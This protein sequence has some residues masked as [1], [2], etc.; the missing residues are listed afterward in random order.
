[1][2]DNIQ[3]YYYIGYWIKERLYVYENEDYETQKFDDRYTALTKAVELR[4][5]GEL[6][7]NFEILKKESYYGNENNPTWI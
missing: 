4:N 6:T 5:D 3:V 7:G 1:M 2:T